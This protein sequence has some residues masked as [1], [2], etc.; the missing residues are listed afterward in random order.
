[1]FSYARVIPFFF[2]RGFMSAFTDWRDRI[3]NRI[4]GT[5][6]GTEPDSKVSG[7]IFEAI[8][9]YGRGQ[10]DTATQKLTQAF[11]ASSAGQRIEAEAT[12]QK[13]Q[14]LMP[15]IILGVV[16]IIAGSYFVFHRR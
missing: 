16:A 2:K 10:F 6:T 9:Q 3:E 4:T 14:E 7:G 12:R 13:I 5:N 8:Y 11:R 1:V 15:M